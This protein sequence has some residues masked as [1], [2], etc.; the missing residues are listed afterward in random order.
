MTSGTDFLCVR[1][2]NEKGQ[3]SEV[4]MKQLENVPLLVSSSIVKAEYFIN[5][6]PGFGNGVNIPVTAGLV[7]LANVNFTI[8]S[9]SLT[10]GTD[11]LYVRT[12][13]EKGQ[14][15]EVLMKQL[16]NVPPAVSPAI[17]KAEYFI[18]TDPGFGNG[19]NIPITAGQVDLSNVSFTIPSASLTAGTDFLFV[20]T[21]NEKGQWSEVLM[22]QLENVP[23]LAA[24]AIV[25]TEYFINS[26]PGFGNG[27]SIPVTAGQVNLTNVNFTIPAAS[28]TPAT[29]FLLLEPKTKKDNGQK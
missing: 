3:W 18:N 29:D 10:A 13:N 27:V 9:G 28:L 1:T 17:V 5:S 11:F 21:K 20:R 12:Q 6:D 22:K 24:P 19:V 8:P 26:D 23:T 14:W 7:D 25:K 2:Q 15:S 16:E 4:M